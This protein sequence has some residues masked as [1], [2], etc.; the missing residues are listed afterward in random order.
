V[1]N[2]EMLEFGSGGFAEANYTRTV[3]FIVIVKIYTWMIDIIST[4]AVATGVKTEAEEEEV[5]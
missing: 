3:A 4:G 2:M 5:A 1:R